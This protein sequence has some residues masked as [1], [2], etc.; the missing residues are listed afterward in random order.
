[1]AASKYL[2]ILTSLLLLLGIVGFCNAEEEIVIH[3]YMMRGFHDGLK[4]GPDPKAVLQYSPITLHIHPEKKEIGKDAFASFRDEMS[5]IYQVPYIIALTSG[6]MIWDGKRENLNQTVLAPDSHLYFIQLYPHSLKGNTF[7][8]RIE[9]YKV[10]FHEIKYSEDQTR[11]KRKVRYGSFGLFVETLGLEEGVGG[12]KWM[13]AEIAVSL[14]ELVLIALPIGDNS[15]YLA[16][17][18]YKREARQFSVGLVG[19]KLL[20]FN[21]SDIDPISGKIVGRGKGFEKKNRAAGSSVY[22]GYTFL[23]DSLSNL[24]RFQDDPDMYLKKCRTKYY[25]DNQNDLLEIKSYAPPDLIVPRPILIV[26]PL[27]PETYRK[28]GFCGVLDTEILV[29]GSGNVIKTTV[30]RSQPS[31]LIESVEAAL[32]Q[33]KFEPARKDG[34]PTAASQRVSFDFSFPDIKLNDSPKKESELSS[35]LDL[36]LL[37][38]AEYCT[39]LEAAALHFICK[40]RI[41]ETIFPDESIKYKVV[42]R[43]PPDW[44]KDYR[45]DNIYSASRNSVGEKNTY[46]YDYQLIRKD[47]R[48]IERRILE[49]ENG[50]SRHD[51]FAPLKTKRFYFYKPIYGPIGL[52]SPDSQ[53][54]YDYSILKEEIIFE[55]EARV[56]EVRPKELIPGK[57]NYGKFWIDKKDASVLKM[58]I[59]AESLGL[60]ERIHADYA[61]RGIIPRITIE[62]EFGLEKKGLRYPTRLLCQ[63]AY[64]ETQEKFTKVSK[65]DVKY[66]EYKFFTVDTEVKNQKEN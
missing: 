52:L 39:R 60:Y 6:A 55:R 1:M 24:K 10:R 33:W 2:F 38:C 65:T 57:P 43:W 11:G 13:D 14:N 36:I 49:E 66:N 44:R 37:K 28:K 8:L 42:R 41:N 53:R 22:K 63:E 7:F 61:S 34:K 5:A 18:A 20:S 30:S 23:F 48:V 32:Q 45:R 31:L 35:D 47:E 3:T 9:T 27:I 46:I 62:V 17:Q 56:V 26:K 12:E 25:V 15:C 21:V 51:A 50:Q 59:E 4:P 16:I 58:E 29:D 54:D 19:H 40:E 64:S